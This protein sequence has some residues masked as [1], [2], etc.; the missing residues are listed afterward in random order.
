MYFSILLDDE[1]TEPKLVCGDT[2]GTYDSPYHGYV[3]RGMVSS[4]YT[5]R[6]CHV[7]Y[8]FAQDGG[9]VSLLVLQY[10]LQYQ[11][12]TDAMWMA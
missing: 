3:Q 4:I 2:G 1:A 6:I 5:K 10:S 11:Q 12:N 7:F 9:A 8:I